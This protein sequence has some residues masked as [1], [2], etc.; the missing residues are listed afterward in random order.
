MYLFVIIGAHR[1]YFVLQITDSLHNV[2]VLFLSNCTCTDTHPWKEKKQQYVTT[3]ALII[4]KL[5]YLCVY[6][7]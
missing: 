2:L 7:V 5:L 6:N 4:V 3:V 1:A